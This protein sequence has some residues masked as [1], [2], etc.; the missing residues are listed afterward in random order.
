MGDKP[1]MNHRSDDVITCSEQIAKSSQEVGEYP[2]MCTY[3]CAPMH[4]HP[5][6]C[7]YVGVPMWVYLCMCTYVVH[8]RMCLSM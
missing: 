8:V 4:V 6:V 2:C 3:V 5:C 7:T 1:Y